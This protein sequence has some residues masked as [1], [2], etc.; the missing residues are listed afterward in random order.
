MFLAND[1]KLAVEIKIY[2]C[3]FKFLL[4]FWLLN[5]NH[6]AQKISTHNAIEYCYYYFHSLHHSKREMLFLHFLY[7]LIL[8]FNTINFLKLISR[9]DEV[10]TN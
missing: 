7:Y 4:K 10:R 2:Y 1:P 9:I 8:K 6:K 3:F 5:A